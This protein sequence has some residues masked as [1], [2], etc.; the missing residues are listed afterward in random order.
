MAQTSRLVLADLTS[1]NASLRL[2]GIGPTPTS[3]D[4]GDFIVEEISVQVA[5]NGN[6][7]AA[8]LFVEQHANLRVEVPTK[9]LF[10]LGN[11]LL[12]IRDSSVLQALAE[13]EW[14][15]LKDRVRRRLAE[16]ITIEI[17]VASNKTVFG[18]TSVVGSKLAAKIW[19]N[20]KL[21][22]GLNAVAPDKWLLKARAS[23]A[24]ALSYP[25]AELKGLFLIEF[26]LRNAD[27]ENWFDI[28]F[29]LD[30]PD[31]PGFDLKFPKVKLPQVS[32][33]DL[34][35][36]LTFD[37]SLPSFFS[38][39]LPPFLEGIAFAWKPNPKLKVRL[40]NG[41]LTV[42]TMEKGEGI[43]TYAGSD[44]LKLS[45]VEL[46][47]ANGKF[48]FT[49]TVDPQVQSFE[50]GKGVFETDW[51]PLKIEAVA[52]IKITPVFSDLTVGTGQTLKNAKLTLELTCAKLVIAAKDDPSSAIAIKIGAR[53]SCDG[54]GK[55]ETEITDLQIVEPYPIAL[56]G[57]LGKQLGELI[58]LIAAIE[59]PTI[60][61]PDA[62]G[63]V[64]VLER[65]VKL[66]AA[67]ARWLANQAGEAAGFLAGVA[68]AI[69]EAIL[70]LI[71][72]LTRLAASAAEQVL[73][74]IAVEIRLD[75]KTYRLRQIIIMPVPGAKLAADVKA[76][77]L[78]FD[79][80]VIAELRPA[81]VIDL[82][83]G[84]WIGIVIQPGSTSTASLATD[85]WLAKET[86]PQQSITTI[87]DKTG[88]PG[89]GNAGAPPRLVQLTAR[90]GVV[91]S[92]A[93]E[94]VLAAVQ[95]GRL[96]L[97]QSFAGTAPFPQKQ[98]VID[99]GKIAF[100]VRET[101]QLTYGGL[102]FNGNGPADAIIDLDL[103]ADG[104]QDRLLSLF[105][106]ADQ[107]GSSGG[108]LDQLKQKIKVSKVTPTFE[109]PATVN[110]ALDL[111]VHIDDDF[112]PQTSLGVAV[113]LRDFSM[114]ITGGDKIFILSRPDLQGNH[115]RVYHPLGLTLEIKK[116]KLE[117]QTPYKQFYLDLSHGNESL[118]L[119]DEAKAEL[120]F[121]KVSTSGKGLQFEVP[122]L[123]VGRT[124]IDLEA[125]IL[126]EPVK[127]GGVDVPFRFTS[128]QVSIKGSKFGGGSLAGA[129]QLPSA[130]VGE[131]NAN[132][133]LQLGAGA[134]GDVIV[135]AATARLDKSGDP[136]RCTSTRFEL[137]ITELGFDYRYEGSYHFFFLLTGSAVFKPGGNE[138]A[139]GLL[140][141]FK[142]VTIKL[143]KAPL[144]AD[145][146]LLLRSI[147][148]QVKVD[149][150][151]KMS[152][153]DIFS[154]DLK[155][156][157]FHPAAPKFDGEPAMNIS[158][159]VHFL[160]AGDRISSDIEFHGLWIARPKAGSSKP[161]VRFDGLTV[162]IRTGGVD[163]EGTAIAVDGSLP[164]LY[165]PGTLPAEIKADGFL[166]NG[167]IDIDGWASMTAAM[168]FLE[169]R[170]DGVPDPKHSFF[171]YGQANKLAVPIRTP[172]GTIYLREA[173]FGF[174]YRYTIAGINEAEKATSPQQLVRILDD[175][176]KYQGN[177]HQFAAWQ[178]T[179]HNSDLTL[180][181]RG[182]FALAAIEGDAY[183]EKREKALPNPLLFD[184]VAAF[185]TD[186]TFL[187][188]LRAWV[189]VNYNDWVSSGLN[190]PWK[191]NPTMRGY[192]YFSV[193]RKEFLGR[194]LSDG[195]GYVGKHPELPKMLADAI[196]KT[197]FSATLYIR[198]GLFHAELGWPYELGFELGKPGDTFYLSMAAG[199]IHRIEDASVLNGIAFRAKG[200]VYLEGRVGGSSLGAAAVARANFAIEAKV[201][202][203]LSLKDFG[204]SFYY[205]YMRIDVA[206]DVSIEVWISFKIF[207]KRIRLSVGFSLHLAVSI[208][209]EAVIGPS[210]VGGRAHVAIGVRA[211]GRT[212]SVGIGFS[213]NN[214]KLADARAKVARFMELGLATQIPDKA[215][216]GQRIEAN[217]KPEPSRKDVAKI[218]DTVVE[219]DIGS[220]PLPRDPE[221]DTKIYPGR[222]IPPTN[223]WAILFPT[224][225]PN[226]AKGEGPWYLM[227][228]VPRDHTPIDANP[229]RAKADELP[230][231]FFSG[232]LEHSLPFAGHRIKLEVKGEI[233]RIQANG[234]AI[235]HPGGEFIDCKTD[236]TAKV[237]EAEG[238]VPLELRALLDTL[239]LGDVANRLLEE[240][241][242]RVIEPD[243]GKLADDAK[244]S[245]HQLGRIG[246]G[247]TNLSGQLKREA[248]IEEARSAIVS[249]VVESAATLAALGETDGQPPAPRN[250]GIDARDFDMSFVLSREAVDQLF[251]GDAEV[252]PP[253]GMMTI[254]KSD[255]AN[256]EPGTVHLFNH[257]TRMFRERQPKFSP[258]HV[259]EEQGIKLNWD[260][261]PA[262]GNSVG[263][264]HDPEFH[265]KHYRIRRTIRGVGDNDFCAE[266]VAKPGSAIQFIAADDNGP[267]RARLLRPEFQF[268]DDL[269]THIG[270]G[271][272]PGEAIPEEL[273]RLL[274]NMGSEEDAGRVGAVV[275]D[276]ALIY[277]IV[278][279]DNA[280]TSDFGEVYVIG[281]F[282]L[283]QKPPRSPREV[284][285]QVAH[286][287]M[288][289]PDI[290]SK[291]ELLL[292]MKP[293]VTQEGQI[294][295]PE[296]EPDDKKSKPHAYLLRIQNLKVAPSGGYGADAVDDSRRRPDSAAIDKM[297][298]PE[299]TDFLLIPGGGNDLAVGA[300]HTKNDGEYIQRSYTCAVRSFKATNGMVDLKGTTAGKDKL[301]AALGLKID[302]NMPEAGNGYRVFLSRVDRKDDL[303]DLNRRGEWKTLAI[304]MVI[305]D[306]V[307]KQPAISSVVEVLERPARLEFAALQRRDMRVESGRVDIVQPSTSGKLGELTDGGKAF[308]VVRDARRRTGMRLEWNARPQSLQLNNS[309]KQPDNLHRWISGFDLFS[310]DPEV[311]TDSGT[312]GLVD[313]IVE[314]AQP[315]GRVSL[316]PAAMR[317][318]DP[319]GFG[320]LGRIEAAYPSDT[321]RLEAISTGDKGGGARK[322]AWY[323]AADTAA[324]FPLPSIRRSLMPDPDE[325]LIA[326]LF[327]GGRPDAIRVSIPA[328]QA[329]KIEGQQNPQWPVLD[330]WTIEEMGGSGSAWG[331]YDK[332]R[333]RHH[334]L[335]A[336][337][338]TR[339]DIVLSCNHDDE[340]R[341]PFTT[342]Q[343]RR[344]LQNLR[345]VP[346]FAAAAQREQEAL[347]QRIAEP[348][349]L[350]NVT[351][352]LEAIRWD[353]VAPRIVATQEISIDVMPRLHPVLADALAFIQYD[354]WAAGGLASA[355]GRLYRRYAVSRDTD[356]E[357]TT[358]EF[359]AY[360][361]QTPAERDPYG[362][363]ALRTFGL[364]AGFR[365]FDTDTNDYVRF[366]DGLATLIDAAFDRALD[367]YGA[368]AR[369]NGQA[370]VDI[371][372]QPWGNAQ[373]SWFDGGR[374]PPSK[375]E[376][377]QEML[378][379]TQIAL[380]PHPERLAVG[381]QIAPTVRYFALT[382]ATNERRRPAWTLAL[383]DVA[384]TDARYDV[385]GAAGG[386]VSQRPL[387]LDKATPTITVF[388]PWPAKKLQTGSGEPRLVV[389]IVREVLCADIQTPVEDRLTVSSEGKGWSFKE[390]AQPAAMVFFREKP[391][392]TPEDLA[393]GRFEDL[394]ADDW[395]DVLF[396]PAGR[397][398][399]SLNRLAYYV[400]RRFAPLDLPE[401][402]N[403]SLDQKNEVAA[404]RTEMANRVVRFWNRFV[405]HCAPGWGRA[406]G[407]DGAGHNRS[408]FFSLGT[409]ADPGHVRR[410]PTAGRL[411]MTVLDVERRGARRKLAVRP[412]GR[413]DAWANA[414]EAAKTRQDT[415]ERGLTGAFP[416]VDDP[417]L[418]MA[419]FVD[420]TLPRTEPLEKP[421]ILSTA[422]HAPT[423]EGRPGRFELVVAH[424]SDMVLAQ[425]NRRNAA[426]LA[427]LDISVGFWR[428]FAHQEWLDA[429]KKKHGDAGYEPLAPF[430][431]LDRR[432]D[433]T[434]VPLSHDM[435]R[436]RLID[437]RQRVP[438]A[439][440][441][442]TMITATQLPYFFRTHALVH[443]A[444]GIVV[445]EQASVTFEEGSYRPG[446]PF[447]PN[448]YDGREA[449]KE[450][451]RYSVERRYVEAEPDP[452]DPNGP[453]L[454][455]ATELPVITFD[456]A[457][458]R[459]I[460]CMEPE[461]AKL[462]FGKDWP[463]GLKRVA[464]LPEPGV[465]YRIS[466]ETVLTIMSNGVPAR[467]EALARVQEINVLPSPPKSVPPGQPKSPNDRLY[468]LQAS[469]SRFGLDE[470]QQVDLG[471]G[472]RFFAT[473]PTPR[474]PKQVEWRI[475]VVVTLAQPAPVLVRALE[476]GQAAVLKLVLGYLPTPNP[477]L[478]PAIDGL[479]PASVSW[480]G[481]PPSAAAW[482]ELVASLAEAG[483]SPEAL[484]IAASGNSLS[485]PDSGIGM[486]LGTVA[487]SSKRVND[488]LSALGNAKIAGIEAI[489]VRRPPTDFE[490]GIFRRFG[491]DGENPAAKLADLILETAET[492][493]FGTGRRPSVSAAKG[494]QASITKP[495]ERR[496]GG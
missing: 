153:F 408:I 488:A 342:A 133:A 213:F 11:G 190:E 427:P 169:L 134:D 450:T 471:N 258:T 98:I 40:E 85:L 391:K 311:L 435:A 55:T 162:A 476:E 305:G 227:Q 197:R 252:A 121:G 148:F 494:E 411:S 313:D 140:K 212:L 356:A 289:S 441:G 253:R 117:L 230:A 205:G 337:K 128:G 127:L 362:W 241:F 402:L 259:K 307:N 324:I 214:N 240:P 239:F 344:L 341:A 381:A 456:I 358:T 229:I 233:W 248:E 326:S 417:E 345:L 15:A 118:G 374:R 111:E 492:Q 73:S 64:A 16:S 42:E 6:N 235:L 290:V 228:L 400:G 131:A 104:L 354:T 156:F 219:E 149:P 475:P 373:L 43:L 487:A 150:P 211:F 364:A 20:P 13:D 195:K 465:T 74:H 136:I 116:A 287:N 455:P 22:D 361:D 159:Q 69:L 468:L 63:F 284:A 210:G 176:S 385:L 462:W 37:P 204:E 236:V 367:R 469:G 446:W 416:K 388:E 286:G 331:E 5:S 4:S 343:M 146:R 215:Q 123:R 106:K 283:S 154:F 186:F 392:S 463:D 110:I 246:R 281:D 291:A 36:E 401:A 384:N 14:T 137:T 260:L 1:G 92:A 271:G 422:V 114:K 495:F 163:V 171:L 244:A 317:G 335:G 448:G 80:T 496:I 222:A 296:P 275:D 180:A 144:A 124:G 249:A 155:G 28:G 129:G 371:L 177:L 196:S 430:G 265:L 309:K 262:W 306:G 65:L 257:Y 405:E 383:K 473:D 459:F 490:L 360:V 61:A 141:N 453:P 100:A 107:G 194:F 457:A 377:T 115:D 366:D 301:F 82:G 126:P 302:P 18:A 161:R 412:Y 329:V 484:E 48:S 493:L 372:T 130:L 491:P 419:Y 365:L 477:G 34:S 138:Y 158:G 208:A 87:N 38:L 323:S 25:P 439:W 193:P 54:A 375:E 404:R 93:T 399:E 224:T 481:P 278:P 437:L 79:L 172:V 348:D 78:G 479:S 461:E 288:P 178:P 451:H 83:P 318:L 77:A 261:E 379:V 168:G 56:I 125:K 97:F 489:V 90:P 17:D 386:I 482:D 382:T 274:L 19:L 255:A 10:D 267:E 353:G 280:G 59:L 113:S 442:S 174:G 293:A 415:V 29:D 268:I 187:I 147:S 355:D 428:E 105:A 143:D 413:Y 406:V 418:G 436:Q 272:R 349:H 72:E 409:V 68:E 27:F 266:F 8:S 185:R 9:L 330:G 295:W 251:P 368:G 173:G 216:D 243:L 119:A 84:G 256:G 45:E 414:V 340:A 217:P 480:S 447:D 198:P 433:L 370:F 445:S 339:F 35:K 332:P 135:K 206:V 184:I 207:G 334:V 165:Q 66:L 466:V 407:L 474:L 182:M 299:A 390:I 175:V 403:Q 387:R 424:G 440:L 32:L 70:Q 192:L 263:A 314:L 170:K 199:L 166:A 203:Y 49:A 242:A 26:E 120:S 312:K 46:K 109:A 304:N 81:L 460:D 200:S 315:L 389:A 202:S 350:A 189:S 112:T 89:S 270:S 467:S 225:R 3:F 12:R 234:K 347:A 157:G 393:F 449:A 432:L 31:L 346:T 320:D 294:E 50:I 434:K 30:L 226:D 102:K 298:A 321:L 269:R 328:W 160:R 201:L 44:V 423:A 209:L 452:N 336:T 421:V 142:D 485:K 179:Y 7:S 220:E 454:K 58:R 273:R 86:G 88:T 431:S 264:Y 285:L 420:T 57:K 398:H 316:L 132:I 376:V 438:D 101:G 96:K 41:D 394:K 325:G 71:K 292:L 122:T 282:E 103:K 483:D 2:E 223:F 47:Q 357:L 75:P 62:S 24:A 327:A 76:S 410:A 33:P 221:E 359:A 300:D 352:R 218:G 232:T 297:A 486:L 188:N 183:N 145:P 333:Q 378:A 191:S 322:T 351:L 60:G 338:E 395:A 443:A 167:K 95:R 303:V 396:R 319:S 52:P 363:G 470:S 53:F 91:N 94:I 444:A 99:G 380:R 247:R 254:I 458:L 426:L 464:H 237:A 397:Q 231:T 164:D 139:T 23:A 245:A 151:K 39:A 429:I 67:A 369:D 308:S 310:I 51:L 181:L 250:T 425:A 276:L 478:P 152:F 279:V 21:V 238:E 277:E 472:N 108:F